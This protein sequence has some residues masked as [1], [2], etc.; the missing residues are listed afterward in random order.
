MSA[1]LDDKPP[2]NPYLILLA[3]VFLPGSG[4]VLQGLA[5]RGLQF[6]FFIIVLG[7]VTTKFA[8]PQASFVGRHAAGVL[9]YAISIFDAYKFARIRFA[10]WQFISRNSADSE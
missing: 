8:S 6:L 5:Q 10:T 1:R 9:I 4:H 3:A 7:W 2:I